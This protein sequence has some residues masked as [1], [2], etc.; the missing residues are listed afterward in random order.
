MPPSGNT[1]K[2]TDYPYL[3]NSRTKR[4]KLP[5]ADIHEKFHFQ[6]RKNRKNSMIP[7]LFMIDL[8]NS[9]YN[10]RKRLRRRASMIKTLRLS[11]KDNVVTCLQA[12]PKGAPVDTGE[13]TTVLAADDIPQ[14]HKIAVAAIGNN[15]LCYKYGE[16]IGMATR[17]IL[18]GEHVHTHNIE[19]TRGRGDKH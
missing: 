17:D 15:A 13:G 9:F 11:H 14:F 8:R 5:Q 4:G 6:G 1:I 12:V 16:I 2:I 7:S 19:S 3:V 10:T 18:P